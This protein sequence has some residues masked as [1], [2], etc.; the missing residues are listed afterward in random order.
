MKDLESDALLNLITSQNDT[1]SVSFLATPKGETYKDI[2]DAIEKAKLQQKLN[3]EATRKQTEKLLNELESGKFQ[4]ALEAS[5]NKTTSAVKE[6]EKYFSE[7]FSNLSA[8]DKLELEN[9]SKPIQKFAPDWSQL[10]QEWR[11]LVTDSK[12]SAAAI[13][14]FSNRYKEVIVSTLLDTKYIKTYQDNAT[15]IKGDFDSLK[16]KLEKFRTTLVDALKEN[17]EKLGS[18]EITLTEDIKKLTYQIG[19]LTS[20]IGALAGVMVGLVVFEGALT[21]FLGFLA[22]PWGVAAGVVLIAGT[23]TGISIPLA[24]AVK[25]R[26]EYQLKD[27]KKNLEI[28]RTAQSNLDQASEKTK[29][30]MLWVGGFSSL[31]EGFVGHL[32]EIIVSYKSMSGDIEKEEMLKKDLVLTGRLYATIHRAMEFYIANMEISTD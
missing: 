3:G 22:G 10:R 30:L 6:M 26:G 29:D 24:E 20:K 2:D 32:E 18:Q 31:W 8:V 9:K 17:L 7:V 23:V 4:S 13:S 19:Y 12:K 27:V 14:I 1:H 21:V 16:N 11:S 25:E 5:V 28:I 15:K